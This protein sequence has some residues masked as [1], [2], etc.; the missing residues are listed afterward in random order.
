MI[1]YNDG[2]ERNMESGQAAGFIK[3]AYEKLK[4]SD[5]E[6]AE[7]LLEQALSIDYDNVEIM[8]ALKCI[9]WW[10]KNTMKL[11]EKEDPYEKGAH[12]MALLKR[13]N[14]FIRQIKNELYEKLKQEYQPKTG[15]KTENEIGAG[16]E[17]KTEL[18]NENKIEN[19]NEIENEIKK[20][21][22]QCNYAVR[23]YV[24]STALIFFDGLL[25]CPANQHDP[26]LLL[27]VG[28]CYKGL[29]NYDSALNYLEQ[30][31]R[32]KREDAETLAEVADI[33]ALLSET[34]AAK[35]L[36]RE[37][38]FIDPVKI[39]L[40]SLESALILQLRDN[41]AAL[42]YKDQALCEWMPV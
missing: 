5:I 34:K 26:G 24:Y 28:R 3:K 16:T 9:S 32:F 17:L 12:M 1:Y 36:F 27:L 4:A 14:V 20:M 42:G 7:A 30:A 21:F 29:G 35:V 38:F 18:K 33:N 41:V 15:I 8:Y 6:N 25:G 2:R 40:H 19:E 31:V 22:E 39:D 11:D 37:A 10:I 23:Y 13:Y